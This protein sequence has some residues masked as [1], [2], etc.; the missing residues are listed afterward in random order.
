MP[1]N[2]TTPIAHNMSH[3]GVCQGVWLFPAVEG[4]REVTGL[5]EAVA[6]LNGIADT[7]H[8]ADLTCP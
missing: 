1:G 3:D 5:P 2:Y 8:N 6:E 4:D 7:A